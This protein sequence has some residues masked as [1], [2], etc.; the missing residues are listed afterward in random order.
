VVEQRQRKIKLSSKCLTLAVEHF[1][2]RHKGFAS[3]NFLTCIDILNIPKI[4]S[5]YQKMISSVPPPMMKIFF[6]VVWRLEINQSDK[7]TSSFR[8]IGSVTETVTIEK[9]CG[10]GRL[11][12]EDREPGGERAPCQIKAATHS[13]G[14]HVFP[15]LLFQKQ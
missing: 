9:P 7:E 5:I 10:F 6:K 4:G 12:E 1:G 13:A 2:A 15:F 8:I 11:V 3:L 14:N